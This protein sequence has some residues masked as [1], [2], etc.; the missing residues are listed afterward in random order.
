MDVKIS[1]SFLKISLTVLCC[2]KNKV[3]YKECLPLMY[4]SLF[5]FIYQGVHF[6]PAWKRPQVS[7]FCPSQKHVRR[8]LQLPWTKSKL[9]TLSRLVDFLFTPISQTEEKGTSALIFVYI[10]LHF[11][12][13]TITFALTAAHQQGFDRIS[14][15]NSNR[16]RTVW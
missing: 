4:S 6:R 16:I 9:C 14:A 7:C 8:H 13:S 2:Y 12:R 10:F 5:A 1:V 11:L 15:I 3:V